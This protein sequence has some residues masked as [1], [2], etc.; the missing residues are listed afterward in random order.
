M[1]RLSRRGI[2]SDCGKEGRIYGASNCRHCYILNKKVALIAHN[3]DFP[4]RLG[5]M[6]K[7]WVFEVK[8]ATQDV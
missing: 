6:P 4:K 1:K 2:C 3:V 7:H 5:M 8:D